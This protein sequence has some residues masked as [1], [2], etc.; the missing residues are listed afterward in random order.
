MTSDITLKADPTKNNDPFL[1]LNYN[2]KF[3][4]FLHELDDSTKHIIR[5]NKQ[6]NEMYDLFLDFVIDSSTF[7]DRQK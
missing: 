5:N 3:Y 4:K 2:V 7:L 1:L 6:L